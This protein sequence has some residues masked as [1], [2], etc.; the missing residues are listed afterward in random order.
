[1]RRQPFRSRPCTRTDAAAGPPPHGRAPL[2]SQSSGTQS[3]AECVCRPEDGG[4]GGGGPGER[5]PTGKTRACTPSRRPHGSEDTG[6]PPPPNRA[7]P[8]RTARQCDTS[9]ASG[10]LG[11]RRRGAHPRSGE[12]GERALAHPAPPRRRSCG[13]RQA[14]AGKRL[15]PAQGAGP[16]RAGR[17][18]LERSCLARPR[19]TPPPLRAFPVHQTGDGRGRDPPGSRET[20]RQRDVTTHYLLS[21]SGSLPSFSPVLFGRSLTCAGT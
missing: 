14:A 19:T 4:G 1:M 15:W 9:P 21:R 5:T 16:R 11:P 2:G 6:R 8:T 7:A 13:A 18:G 10:A 12:R 17:R 20:L 3:A